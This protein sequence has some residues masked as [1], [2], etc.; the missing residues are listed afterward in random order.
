LSK[1]HRVPRGLADSALLPPPPDNRIE[2]VPPPPPDADADFL[3][4]SQAGNAAALAGLLAAHRPYLRHIA[5]VRFDDRL[6]GRLDESD[7][8]QDA[9]AEAVRRAPEFATA[10]P[11]PVR[12]WLRRLLLDA[13]VAAQRRHLAAHGRAAGREIDL[14]A[15]SVIAVADR[16]LANSPSPASEAARRERAAL[17][18]TALDTLAAD[19]REVI[20]LRAFESQ[21]TADTAAVLGVTAEA[22][23][24]RFV[25]AMERL[26]A[27]LKDLGLSGSIVP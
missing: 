7:V 6:R 19:D 20:V 14:S 12:L 26:R 23:S 5:G 1:K 27:A 17:V 8:V 2:G 13:L 18:R 11:L 9:L 25:R 24:K 15:G 3:R 22:A 4:A 10:R 16:L 21:N